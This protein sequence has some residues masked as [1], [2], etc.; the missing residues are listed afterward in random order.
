MCKQNTFKLFEFF[1]FLI[2][3]KCVISSSQDCFDKD[4]DYTSANLKTCT[5][6]DDAIG[7]Q[8]LC[9]KTNECTRF[10]YITAK[11]D[12]QYGAGMKGCCFL[13]TTTNETLIDHGGVMAGP[14]SC[15]V[16]KNSLSSFL[17]YQHTSK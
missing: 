11:Y 9:E 13:K 8:L 10:S 2:F 12:G 7:C 4:K 16:G 3:Q 1:L 6:T 14:K 5:K 15:P 17:L